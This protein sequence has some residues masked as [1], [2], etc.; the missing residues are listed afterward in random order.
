MPQA[1]RRE[2]MILVERVVRPLT[3]PLNRRKRVRSELLD[4]LQAIHAEELARD[5]DEAAALARTAQRFGDPAALTGELRAT[6]PWWVCWSGWLYRTTA[7]R[8]KESVF[9]FT[10]RL[11]AFWMFA[12][13]LLALPAR[14]FVV[15]FGRWPLTWVTPVHLAAAPFLYTWA[16]LSIVLGLY[17]GAE[18]ERKPRRW[19]RI[20]LL[21]I[22]QA[23]IWPASLLLMMWVAGGSW[24]DHPSPVMLFV[25]GA[26]FNIICWTAVGV[27]HNRELSYRLE[28]DDLPLT[29]Q[30]TKL[31]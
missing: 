13:P 17:A 3:L 26:I 18:L 16:P 27:L 19:L 29:D 10:T 4:H 20:V 28:W 23:A 25:V 22:G 2:L 7:R 14:A 31:M 11:L 30:L 15:S 24:S 9:W 6:I 5:G 1:I 12:F 21:L 8:P